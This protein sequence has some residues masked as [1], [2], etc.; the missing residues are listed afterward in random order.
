[1]SCSIRGAEPGTTVASGRTDCHSV[2][3]L[4]AW[5]EVDPIGC[6]ADSA[7]EGP[8]SVT[9]AGLSGELISAVCRSGESCHG[10]AVLLV[11]SVCCCVL[12]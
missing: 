12:V 4:E 7:Y 8:D 2:G 6:A 10:S 11:H 3:Y 1:M 9:W 5:A